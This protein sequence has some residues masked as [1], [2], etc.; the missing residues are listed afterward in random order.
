MRSMILISFDEIWQELTRI[1]LALGF[2]KS[3]AKRCARIFTENTCDG[4]D[5]HG[6]NR[7]PGFVTAVKTGLVKPR[8]EP[9]LV[10]TFG[11]IERWDGKRG[12]GPLNAEKAM[13]RAI[14]LSR[15]HG[16]GCVGE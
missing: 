5:S 8:V 2:E 7:F 4:V 6:L 9:E 15:G 1:L 10:S 13:K 3:G 14:K 12:A 16:L 11:A